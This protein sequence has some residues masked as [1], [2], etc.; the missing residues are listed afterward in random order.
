VPTATVLGPELARA[1]AAAPAPPVVMALGGS[2]PLRLDLPALPG[3]RLAPDAL[4]TLSALYLAARL[5]DTGVVQVAEAL[6]RRRATLRVPAETAAVLED[7]ARRQPQ[8][9]TVAERLA[10]FAQLFGTGPAAG[11]DPAAAGSRFEPRLAALCSALVERGRQ[12][13]RTVDGR[14]FAVQLAGRDLAELAGIVVGG[15]ATLAVGRLNDQVRRSIDLL[16]DPG[17]GALVGARGTWATLRGLLRSSAPDLRRLIDCGR[18][19]Q[20]ILLWLS[21]T[22][23]AQD[24]ASGVPAAIPADVVTSAAAWLTAC[25]LPPRTR[26]EGSI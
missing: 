15:G 26:G 12:P 23:A 7:L 4:R 25:G 5:E 11:A 13:A 20:R 6:V 10:L 24:T 14:R 17:I 1:G 9:F 18:H 16:S 2:D 22:T 19:G 8:S 3:L 21:T